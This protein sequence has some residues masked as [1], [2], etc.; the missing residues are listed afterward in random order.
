MAQVRNEW[1]PIASREM[2]IVDERGHVHLPHGNGAPVNVAGWE[3]WASI[4]GGG[5]MLLAGLAT[6]RPLVG[7]ITALT[8][9]VFLCRGA[10]G[11]CPM[12][13]SLG[14]DTANHRGTTAVPA[15]QGYRIQES[16]T[17]NHPRDELFRYWRDLQNLPHLMRHI[18]RIEPVDERRSRWTAEGPLG[19][20]VTWEAEI[21]NERENELI[22]WRSLEG[23]DVDTA[24]SVHFESLPAGRGTLIRVSLKYNP[25]AGKV[26]AN[27]ASLLGQGVDSE[28]R[29]DLCRFKSSMEAGEVPTTEGQPVG[30][31]A[32]SSM[33]SG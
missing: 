21:F 31:V 11:H 1:S 9:G 13:G 33:T 14:I 29:E 16:I 23:G 30:G 32:N 10:T 17:V 3:R 25:P 18:R 5:G 2:G 4:V 7:I 19:R 28:I 12:Y 24:G 8:G 6:R 20:S 26:G 15:Q 22:A 27:I